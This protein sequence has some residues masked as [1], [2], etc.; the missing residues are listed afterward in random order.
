MGVRLLCME[1]HSY[2]PCR[3]ILWP[4]K[5]NPFEEVILPPFLKPSPCM[6]ARAGEIVVATTRVETMLGDTAVA[7]HPEDPR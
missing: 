7:V 3:P 4:V 6:L 5:T 2:L 1:C